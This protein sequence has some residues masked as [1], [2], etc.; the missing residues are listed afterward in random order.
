MSLAP[1]L[2]FEMHQGDTKRLRVSVVDSDG[3]AVSLVGAQS[4]KWWAA[5]KVT[6]TVRLLEKSVASGSI[7]VLDAAGGVLS[8]PILPAD[9]AAITGDYYHELEVIDS[10]GDIG[11]VLIGTMTVARA[12][13]TNPP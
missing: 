9:T 2:D 1:T 8:I 13:V 12:L 11:T 5:K 10:A 6:S 7:T 4:I 3:A